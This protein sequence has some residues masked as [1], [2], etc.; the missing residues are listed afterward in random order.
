[1]PILLAKSSWDR[2]QLSPDPLP[3]TG[4]IGGFRS[5]ATSGYMK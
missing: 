4:S 2:T 3:I 1:M 5:F